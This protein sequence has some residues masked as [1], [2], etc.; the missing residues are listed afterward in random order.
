MHVRVPH[1]VASN[2]PGSQIADSPKSI[3]LMSG[4]APVGV[5]MREVAGVLG[6]P[7]AMQSAG[8]AGVATETRGAGENTAAA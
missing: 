8:V 5:A 1:V 6:G 7:A 2:L 4:G 3:N